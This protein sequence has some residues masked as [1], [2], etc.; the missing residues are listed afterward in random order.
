MNQKLQSQSL[1]LPPQSL[2]SSS[3]ATQKSDCGLRKKFEKTSTSTK[4]MDPVAKIDDANAL[5]PKEPVVA[6]NANAV[7]AA[8]DGEIPIPLPSPLGPAPMPGPASE[9]SSEPDHESMA[10]SVAFEGEITITDQVI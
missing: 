2:L 5:S 6:L 3:S 7:N 10:S 1:F 8:H 4:K 9:P